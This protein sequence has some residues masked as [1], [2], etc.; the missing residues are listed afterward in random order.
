MPSG[1]WKKRLY[2]PDLAFPLV[3]IRTDSR[4]E[5]EYYFAFSQLLKCI[6]DNITPAVNYAHISSTLPRANLPLRFEGM[7][8]DVAYLT[9]RETLVQAQV[10][11]TPKRRIPKKYLGV[12]VYKTPTP[13]E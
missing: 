13:G 11:I 4:K 3:C 6:Y 12:N 1:Y 2:Y 9:Y 8:M 7:H 10:H 5:W